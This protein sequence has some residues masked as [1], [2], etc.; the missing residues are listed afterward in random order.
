[1]NHVHRI[2]AI[3]GIATLLSAGAVL[4]VQAQP[5][6]TQIV[7]KN[8]AEGVFREGLNKIEQGDFQ[9]AIDDFTAVLKLNPNVPDAY[10]FRGLARDLLEDNE[11][12]IKD[13][14]EAIR[15]DPKN[16]YAYNNRGTVYAELKEYQK[17]IEDYDRALDKDAENANAYYN[18]AL[19]HTAIGKSENALADFQKAADL[20]KKQGQTA[21]YEDALNRIKEL[22]PEP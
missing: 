1:M 18:R 7:Q 14:S 4:S 17:A 15:L 2:T 21:D 8:D 10:Y 5:P 20:Y 12:A 6:Q 16:T 9:G 11:E 22:N 3:L 13:Y 19:A